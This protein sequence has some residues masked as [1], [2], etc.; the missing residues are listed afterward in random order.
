MNLEINKR[1]PSCSLPGNCSAKSCI[2]FAR[3]ERAKCFWTKE[4]WLK[5]CFISC[6]NGIEVEEVLPCLMDRSIDRS[7]EEVGR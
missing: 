5:G 3:E 7:R 1:G 2:V 6:W 4:D